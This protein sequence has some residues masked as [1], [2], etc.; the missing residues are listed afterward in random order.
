M[1]R[2]SAHFETNFVPNSKK[3]PICQSA[4]WNTTS[5]VIFPVDPE[6]PQEILVLFRKIKMTGE[7]L[8]VI[9]CEPRSRN[10]M[11]IVDNLYRDFWQLYR[12]LVQHNV[13]FLQD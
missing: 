13:R 4:Y 9:G 7:M 8:Y 2:V 1:V 12:R 5:T 11:D 10:G 3:C 6:V